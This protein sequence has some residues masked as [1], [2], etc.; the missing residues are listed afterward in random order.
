MSR[1]L[2][3]ALA[4]LLLLAVATPVSADEPEPAVAAAGEVVPG[5][6]IVKWR[7]ATAGDAT[8]DAHGLSVLADLGTPA[9]DMPEVVSTE[10]RHVAEVPTT[11]TDRVAG[12]SR[13]DIKKWLPHYARLWARAVRHGVK[14]RAGLA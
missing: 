13:F 10:G 5:E 14:K 9:A 3:T 12:E 8:A 2:S 6:V 7:D 11:W 4:L 1:A